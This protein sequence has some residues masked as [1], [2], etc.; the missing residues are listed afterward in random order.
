MALTLGLGTGVSAL[1]FGMVGQVFVRS[2]SHVTEPG[3][4]Y[5]LHI[6]EYDA[7]G[8]PTRR[9]RLT[10]PEFA[11]LSGTAS[12]TYSAAAYAPPV[13]R[14]VI[15]SRD[16]ERILLEHSVRV[17]AV[18]AEFFDVLGT[19]STAGRAF[20]AADRSDPEL[21]Q[22]ATVVVGEAFWQ[23]VFG[24]HPFSTGHTLL[25]QQRR[26]EIIG[27]LPADFAGIDIDAPDIWMTIANRDGSDRATNR[28]WYGLKVVIRLRPGVTPL[29]A[30]SDLTR[31]LHPDAPP[32]GGATGPRA[33]LVP[34]E[35]A[36]AADVGPMARMLLLLMACGVAV[37]LLGCASAANM[38][39]VRLLT[40]RREMGVRMALGM[41]RADLVRLLTADWIVLALVA[42]VAA[43]TV[44][45][46][47]S[48]VARAL[49]VPKLGGDAPLIDVRMIGF[50]LV[51]M[52]GIAAAVV[53]FLAVQVGRVDPLSAITE[54]ATSTRVPGSSVLQLLTMTQLALTYVMLAG[55]ALFVRSLH[56]AL[57]LDVGVNP[58]GVAFVHLPFD[59]SGYAR[60]DGFSLAHRIRERAAALPGVQGASLASGLPLTAY[61]MVPVRVAGTVIPPTA[62][63]GPN[64]NVVQHDY[65]ATVG[66]RLLSGR[67]FTANDIRGADRVAIVNETM[68]RVVWPADDAMGKCVLVG[69]VPFHCHR[70]IGVTQDAHTFGLREEQ[71]MQYYIPAAQRP[72][73]L[74]NPY[75]IVRARPGFGPPLLDIRRIVEDVAPS[76]RT[77]PIGLLEETLTRLTRQWRVGT[78]VMVT[79]GVLTLLVSVAGVYGVV[80]LAI[81]HRERECCIRVALGAPTLS[82]LLLMLRA[83]AVTA[84]AALAAGAI[85]MGA[86]SRQLAPLLFEVS[87][88]DPLAHIMAALTVVVSTAMAAGIPAW[89]ASTM[90]PARLSAL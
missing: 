14:A 67:S 79:F 53:V 40:R 61:N 90:S 34:I 10:Y 78:G 80:A 52:T 77:Y 31:A 72:D 60:A 68:A 29:R 89:R 19:P 47:G 58:R 50:V 57:T 2:P 21:R 69:P 32:S 64:V 71:A 81:T 84:L 1:L 6:V 75:L 17:G 83:E 26:Y 59:S 56:N 73:L 23:S 82:V 55:A 15:A 30:T 87:P 85:V 74:A 22:A 38:L 46:F 45:W 43:F 63:G 49:L 9:P 37:M 66:T 33:V 54:R 65:F 48:D 28:T 36:R 20:S 35:A 39:L 8:R 42:G 3:R 76:L 13:P 11:A 70:V 41:T 24:R 7:A 51:S 12:G 4:L 88:A 62:G 86:A 16:G 5:R 18:S 25:I 27:V 44:S